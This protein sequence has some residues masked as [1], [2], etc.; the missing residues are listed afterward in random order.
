MDNKVDAVIALQLEQGVVGIR[1][2][3]NGSLDDLGLYL[4][5]YYN[6]EEKARNLIK[7][8]NLVKVEKDLDKVVS[9][10]KETGEPI[11]G[12]KAKNLQNLVRG[13]YTYVFMR[14]EWYYAGGKAIRLSKIANA[15]P[16]DE[17]VLNMTTDSKVYKD[18]DSVKER[19]MLQIKLKKLGIELKEN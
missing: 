2:D 13:T 17:K 12:I 11:T 8:G 16:K 18:L 4:Y 15:I 9:K 19:M 3:L 1:C 7:L 10:H 5:L 6:T 14:G